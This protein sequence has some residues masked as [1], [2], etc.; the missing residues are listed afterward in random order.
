MSPGR[1]EW[2]TPQTII[3]FVGMAAAFVSFS[4]SFDRRI[5]TVEISGKQTDA[6]LREHK[7]DEESRLWRIEQKIDRMLE[8]RR[9]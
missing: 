2:F 4:V 9:K 8:E 5:T 3:A 6:S 7:A 1:N